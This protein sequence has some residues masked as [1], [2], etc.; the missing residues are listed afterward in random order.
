MFSS[1]DKWGGVLIWG[2]HAERLSDHPVRPETLLQSG[3]STRSGSG[4]M[5]YKPLQ[6][7]V[8][9]ISRRYAVLAWQFALAASLN[10]R[11]DRQCQAAKRGHSPA[12]HARERTLVRKDSVLTRRSFRELPSRR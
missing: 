10:A 2:S 12:A 3:R 1:I 7:A 5:Q 6:P 4:V 8:A 11:I 9:P